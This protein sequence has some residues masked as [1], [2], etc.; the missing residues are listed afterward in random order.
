M[1]GD[2]AFADTAIVGS[3]TIPASLESLGGGVF[4]ACHA[5]TEIKVESGNKIYADIDGVVYTNDGK[6]AV[7]YPAGNPAENYTVLDGTQ[8]IGIAAFYGSW[9]LRGVAVRRV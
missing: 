4:G 6:T 5:L 2:Y 7:A 3:V 1:I 9:N 8:K